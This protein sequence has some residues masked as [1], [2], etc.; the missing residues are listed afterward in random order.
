[1]TLKFPKGFYWGSA[2]SAHQVEGNNVNDWSEWEKK[3]AERLA[4]EA[5][6]KWQP[7]QQEKFPEMFNPENYISGRACDHYHLYEQDFDIAKKLGHNAHRFSIEWSRIEPEQGKFNEKEIEHYRKVILAL[8]KRGI[9]PFVTLWHWTNPLWIRDIGGW[10]NKKITDYFERYAEKIS[11]ALGENVKF[12]ITLNEPEIYASNSYFA[13]VW[14][15]QKKNL[16]AYLR[17]LNNLIKAHRKA[18][19]VIKK[20]NSNSKIGIAKNN[21]YFEAYQNKLV[22]RVLKKFIDWWWNFYFLNRIRNH[23]DFI[24]LNHYFHNRINYGFNKNENKKISD[25]GWELYPEAIYY[26]LKDLKR[27]NKP[28]Y[29]TENGLADGGDKKRSWFILESLKNIGKAINEGVNVR[30]YLHW[31]LMDN[32]EWDKGFWPRFGLVEVNYKTLERKIRPSALQYAKICKTNELI[33]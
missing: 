22:N 30:G 4:K 8:K 24:G 13:G 33:L 1:M 20:A 2:T 31:S 15:P 7:W 26:V 11:N 3:N 25:I 28:I 27:F 14:P 10:E 21:I 18:Y 12:W 5:K 29:I 19:G 23:Q 6:E 16:F 32:F 17:V 9:E